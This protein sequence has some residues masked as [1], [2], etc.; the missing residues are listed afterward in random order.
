MPNSRIV[1]DGQRRAHSASFDRV[2]AEVEREF[3]S[4]LKQA[5]FMRRMV[6]RAEMDREITRRME[7]I[8]PPWALYWRSKPARRHI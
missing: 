5:G 7:E 2:R 3:S 6:L 1:V 4:A 8:A